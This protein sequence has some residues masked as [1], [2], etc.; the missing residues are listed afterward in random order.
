MTETC[1]N[2][3]TAIAKKSLFRPHH[4]PSDYFGKSTNW[5]EC[6]NGLILFMAS[7]VTSDAKHTTTPAYRSLLNQ[8]QCVLQQRKWFYGFSPHYPLK[9]ISPARHFQFISNRSAISWFEQ[10]LFSYMSQVSK[11]LTQE[12]TQ[13]KDNFPIVKC[14][15][16]F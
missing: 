2:L 1:A 8:C 6:V 10:R 3:C 15:T 13:F 9:R 16:S 14:Q 11:I 4:D 5:F 7:F 12:F